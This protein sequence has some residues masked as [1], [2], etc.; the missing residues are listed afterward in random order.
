MSLGKVS[1]A[2][3]AAMAGFE[4]DMGRAQRLLEKE[5][6]RMQKDLDGF[7]MKAK[8]VGAAVG[9]AIV[10]G[11]GVAAAAVK[12]A[13]DDMDKLGETAQKVG[14]PTEQLSA[15]RYAAK[16]SGVESE[17]LNASLIKLSKN[18]ADTAAGSG[19]AQKGFAALGISVKNADGSLKPS[20]QVLTEIAGKFASYKDSAEKTA[21]AVNLFGKSGAEL[22]PLL[23]Q[24]SEGIANLEEEA[25]RLGVTFD[26]D[27]ANK[28]G[29]FNDVL[30]KMM[31]AVQGVW[32]QVAAQL[33]PSLLALADRFLDV[34]KAGGTFSSIATVIATG[35]KLVGTVAAV[36]VGVF[37]T[38]GEA[39]GGVA[40]AA[41]AFITGDFKGAL[42]IVN[43]YQ[44]DIAKNVGGTIGTVKDIWA[45]TAADIKADAPKTSEGIAAPMIQGEE[46]AKKSGKRMVD[47]AA[48]DYKRAKDELDRLKRELDNYG[49]S[50]EEKKLA[51]FSAMPGATPDMIAEYQ[52]TL[53]TISIADILK[54][55]DDVQAENESDRAKAI[56]DVNDALAEQQVLV[57]MS[58][59]QQEVWNNLK[60][61]GVTAEDAWGRQI[62]ASTEALQRQRDA[63]DD[64]IEAMDAVRSAGKDLFKDLVHG[65]NPLD[66]MKKALDSIY[67]KILDIIAQ[68]LM[69]SLFGKSGSPAGGM[70]G[71]FFSSIFGG[72]FG[73]GRAS[74]GTTRA[75][76]F[77]EVNE[78][79]PE[80]YSQGG[81]TFLMMGAEDGH[82]T[83]LASGT[84]GSQ[85]NSRRV[86]NQSVNVTISGRPD[87]RTPEQIAR[88]AGRESSRALARTGR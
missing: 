42:G 47:Q 4:S 17:T 56:K 53:S 25:R 18:M 71:G 75:G 10:G 37:K 50:D 46:K 85:G 41:I 84:G 44:A 9:A 6:K 63:M 73:G 14:L 62:I 5:T 31:V 1:I 81:K 57:G 52:S 55:A 51:D 66:A 24:G 45:D 77:Y 86:L 61:A 43:D 35:L 59:D 29:A 3:E 54:E 8:A 16:L 49:K 60:W 48:R 72:L 88:A 15:L 11:L 22:I 79:A 28:A 34:N 13:I 78:Q 27:T 32:N 76:R 30:D 39:L 40:A 2:I 38:V 80:L 83:P 19:E 21:L 58:R 65:E 7:Q 33:L 74:G 68:N 12:M 64:Q 20:S 70:T 23:N 26:D 87:R 36:V 82:V 69:D 67:D